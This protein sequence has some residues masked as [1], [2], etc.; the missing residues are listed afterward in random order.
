[1]Y[2]LF[3]EY[4]CLKSMATTNVSYC[5]GSFSRGDMDD[6]DEDMEVYWILFDICYGIFLIMKL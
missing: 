6:H 1:M 5:L 2:K 3:L 4:E